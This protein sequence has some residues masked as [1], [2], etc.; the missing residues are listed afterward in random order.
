M[1]KLAEQALN[2]Q[3]LLTAHATGSHQSDVEYMT[4][5]Q[6][7]MAD[8]RL[9]EML[10][11]FVRTCRSLSQ[12]W[13]FIKPQFGTYRERRSYIWEQFA[14][15]LTQLEQGVLHPA[16]AIVSG[17]LASFDRDHVHRVWSKAVERRDIDPEG[18]ITVARTLLESVCKRIL[19]NL[20]IE[21]SDS[22][23][24]PKLYRTT[25]TAL[26]LAPDQHSEL[27]FKQILGGC[28]SVVEG[29]GALRNRL[30]DA[31]GKGKAPIRPAAR[32][33]ELAVNLAGAAAIFLVATWEARTVGQD[34]KSSDLT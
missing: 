32:H 4:L 27:V 14:P 3:N 21:Y 25:A 11:S 31:H 28:T 17:A 1:N 2:L 8:P 18:A 30:S 34:V 22:I 9:A 7:F 12:F 24:L 6:V 5:R 16:D 26:T 29:L 19:D 10:P 23:E 20:Q 13:A 33:A 15:L